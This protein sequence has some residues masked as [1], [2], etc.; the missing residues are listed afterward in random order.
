MSQFDINT[1]TSCTAVM[2]YRVH[3]VTYIFSIRD[4]SG[5]GS[6]TVIVSQ[7]SL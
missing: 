2:P 3:F 5:V 1:S 7:L 4:V 6:V